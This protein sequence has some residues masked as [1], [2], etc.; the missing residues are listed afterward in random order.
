MLPVTILSDYL[1]CP[2]K[3]YLRH[4]MKLLPAVRKPTV[5]GKIRHDVFD[6]ISKAEESLILS[7]KPENLENA[8]VIYANAYKELLANSLSKFEEDIKKAEINKEQLFSESLKN[9]MVQASFNSKNIVELIRQ[10]GLFGQDLINAIPT[11]QQSELFISSP[12]LRL[13]G[14]IDRVEIMGDS[15]IPVELKTGSMPRDGVWPNHKVQLAAYILLLKEKYV[16]DYGFLEYLDY[17]VRR[18]VVMNPFLEDEVKGVIDKV[19]SLVSS[20]N[21]P[22]TCGNPNKCR[23]CDLRDRCQA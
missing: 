6:A 9:F 5:Q 15:Y 20:D 18:K 14:I 7:I 12:T 22:E 11:K 21:V 8:N 2:R 4:V 19:H 1:Y 13:K 16:S 3:V 23:S 17:G 10:T